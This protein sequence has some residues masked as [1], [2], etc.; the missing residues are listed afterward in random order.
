MKM[1]LLLK[2]TALKDNYTI[3]HLY[4]IKAGESC[5]LCDTLE[6]KVRD[7]NKNGKFDNGEKKVYGK[8]A[9]PYG[10]YIISM[11]DRSPKYSNYSRYPYA[12]PYGA[13]MPRLLNVV[14][15]D[16]VL[17]HPGTTAED[18][19]GCILVG[20][21]KKVGM[22]INSQVTWKR[23]MDTLFMPAKSRNEKITITIK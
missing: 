4:L 19:L 22:L 16:G 13:Y 10:T 8:T 7:L 14:D 6:D 5:Y 15:F 20:E 12:K 21:N 9:I 3:G 23:L 11:R 1:E 18:S 2:R 17:I